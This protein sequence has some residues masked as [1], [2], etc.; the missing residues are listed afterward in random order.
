MSTFRP[1]R[2][3][4]RVLCVDDDE[5]ILDCAERYL[6]DFEVVRFDKPHDALVY[7]LEGRDV[8]VV[9]SDIMM[10]EMSGPELYLACFQHSPSLA[11]RFI[12]TSGDIACAHRLLDAAMKTD[13]TLRMPQLLEKPFSKETLLAAVDLSRAA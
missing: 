12:F 3:Q 9:V 7:V 2:G 13:V 1:E 6:R 8:D 5:L 4:I 10:P 11:R